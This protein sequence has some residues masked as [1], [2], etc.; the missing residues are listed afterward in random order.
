MAMSEGV[1]AAEGLPALLL[2][3]YCLATALLLLLRACLPCYCLDTAAEG[4]PALLL[5]CYCC[6]GPACLA[7]AAAAQE[8][9]LPMFKPHPM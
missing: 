4:L 3:C 2:P 9:L 1:A 6:R 5:P 8:G 7:T